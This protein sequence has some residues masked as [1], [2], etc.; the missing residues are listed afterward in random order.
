MGWLKYYYLWLYHQY[1]VSLCRIDELMFCLF[2]MAIHNF[3]HSIYILCIVCH[4][5]SIYGIVFDDT[6]FNI[7]YLITLIGVGCRMSATS[8]NDSSQVEKTSV[9][10]TSNDYFTSFGSVQ[11]KPGRGDATLSMSCFDKITRWTVVGVQ[12]FSL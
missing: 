5:P 1:R 8:A 2:S 10:H 11:K 4:D 7:L 9:D 6:N 12:G 3:D